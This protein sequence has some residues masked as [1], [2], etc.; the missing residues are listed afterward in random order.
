MYRVISVSE[1]DLKFREVFKRK[2]LN[3]E[4]VIDYRFS[5]SLPDLVFFFFIDIDKDWLVFC[6]LNVKDCLMLEA[7][8][9]FR[10][11]SRFSLEGIDFNKYSDGVR[12]D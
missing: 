10:V 1:T 7:P 5:E 9:D 6:E 11:L 8:Q 2:G 4:K 12:F 3:M